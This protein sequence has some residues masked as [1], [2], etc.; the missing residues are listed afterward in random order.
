MRRFDQGAGSSVVPL[1]VCTTY[2]SAVTVDSSFCSTCGAA[3]SVRTEPAER[4]VIAVLFGDLVQSTELSRHVELEQLDLFL[5][6]FFSEITSVIQ[7]HGGSIEKFIGDAVVA[8]FGA[9]M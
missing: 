2:V 1:S 7:L 4:K 3:L 9:P 8:L 6:R 5:K